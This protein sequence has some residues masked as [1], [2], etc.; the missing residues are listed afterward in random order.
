M[1]EQTLVADVLETLEVLTEGQALREVEI[2]LGPEVNRAGAEAAWNVLSAGTRFAST[3]VTWE[4]ATDLLGCE[5]CHHE[6]TSDGTGACPYCGGQGM[7]LEP[8]VPISVGHWE[9]DED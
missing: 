9:I 6:F 2:A 4:Q 3:H 5:Q 8:A 7:V 1:H